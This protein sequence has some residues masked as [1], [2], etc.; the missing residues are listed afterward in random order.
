MCGGSDKCH[1]AHV[2]VKGQLAFL[3][4]CGWSESNSGCQPWCRPLYLLSRLSD[5]Q[6]PFMS[7]FVVVT[8]CCHIVSVQFGDLY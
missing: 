6:S 7:L 3:Q 4:L 2:Q 1:E 8:Y 5:P